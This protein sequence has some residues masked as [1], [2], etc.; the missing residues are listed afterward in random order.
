MNVFN[1][2]RTFKLKAERNWDTLY[3]MVDLHGTLIKPGKD[4]EFYPGAVEVIKWFNKHP[5]FKVILWTSSYRS[6]IDNFLKVCD[7]V[8]VSFDLINR[9]P[10]EK[11]TN[12]VCFDQKFYF[13]IL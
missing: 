8:G 6:E 4:I 2:E 12:T 7:I 1:I 13:N 5:Y 11:N 9:N 10:L 3:V